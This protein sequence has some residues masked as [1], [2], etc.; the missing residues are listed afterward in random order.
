VEAGL[1]AQARRLVGLWKERGAPG[2]EAPLSGA[3]GYRRDED[4]L[5]AAREELLGRLGACE[6]GTWHGLDG[7]LAILREES[8]HLLRPQNRLVRDL[9]TAQ[10]REALGSWNDVE[11]RWALGALAGPLAWLHVVEWVAEPEPVFRL[12]PDGAWLAGRLSRPPSNP[13]DPRL[14][15]H[16]D[17]RVRVSSPDSAVLWTLAGFARPARTGGRPVYLIDRRSVARARAVG[18]DPRTITGFLRRHAE[19]GVPQ[20]LVERIGEWG[21]EPHRI[22]LRPALA[23]RC[24]TEAG[25]EEL[26]ASPIVR[27]HHPRRVGEDTVLLLLPPDNQEEELRTLTRRLTRSGLFSAD[28]A[29][30]GGRDG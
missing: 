1:P 11:G 4:T 27:L 20:P 22:E 6:P 2:E 14:G 18:L 16:E 25:V 7:L 3:P 12:T 30:N 8:P 15:M 19:S 23:V 9:G 24:E 26:L 5:K 28:D 29:H 13:G 17:G 10:A 21:R